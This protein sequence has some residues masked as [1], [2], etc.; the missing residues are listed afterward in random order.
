MPNFGAC[1]NP[2]CERFY[3]KVSLLHLRALVA[4]LDARERLMPEEERMQ[5]EFPSDLE[6]QMELFWP[7]FQFRQEFP[8]ECSECHQALHPIGQ[9]TEDAKLEELLNT[10]NELQRWDGAF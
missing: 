7:F 8:A 10:G 9:P 5:L 6:Q 3:R 2:K 4:V 1:E